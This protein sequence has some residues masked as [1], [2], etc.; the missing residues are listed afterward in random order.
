VLLLLLLL[1]V[2]LLE[3]LLVL[4]PLHSNGAG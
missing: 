2:E 4:Q 3:A 1:L